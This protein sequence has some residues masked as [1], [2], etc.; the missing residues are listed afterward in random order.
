M[1]PNGRGIVSG[2]LAAHRV[3]EVRSADETLDRFESWFGLIVLTLARNELK[4]SV[5]R[6]HHPS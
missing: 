5:L 3:I 4:V 2:T 1:A 6:V